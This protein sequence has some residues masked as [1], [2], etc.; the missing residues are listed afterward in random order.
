MVQML[1]CTLMGDFL[2]VAL[3]VLLDWSSSISAVGEAM[4]HEGIVRRLTDLC[5]EQRP[6]QIERCIAG[7]LF[8]LS[9]H[10]KSRNQMVQDGTLPLVIDLARS[11]QDSLVH[12]I[13]YLAKT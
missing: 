9:S 6:V 1:S 12:L 5:S 2:L 13:N 4:L 3:E 7:V 10:V 11:S 8:S